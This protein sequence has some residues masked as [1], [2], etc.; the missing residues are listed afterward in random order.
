[1]SGRISRMGRVA[2]HVVDAKGQI[3]GRL[4]SQLAPLLRGKHKPT[5]MPNVDCGDVVIVLNAEHI[6]LTGNKWNDKLYRWHTGYPGGLKE[7]TAQQIKD[8]DPADI[9]RKAVL[10]MLPKNK[11]R[12]L[13]AQ[14]LKIF[15]G[16][17][18][19]FHAE[20]GPNPKF[21]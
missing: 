11:M 16:E 17:E 20:L 10:G 5:Y 15:P 12:A 2:Y 21:L 9:L 19:T 14:K 1:M 7:R 3:A 4:A 18:H 8:R 6:V 13:Q